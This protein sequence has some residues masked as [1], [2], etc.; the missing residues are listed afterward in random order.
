MTGVHARIAVL[1]EDGFDDD[2]LEFV[3]SRL[4]KSA[5]VPVL[6]GPVAHRAYR[7]RHG[8]VVL[9][10]SSSPA[11]A[12]SH[13]FA[14]IVIPAGYAP[15][16]LRMRHNVL[17]MVR[18]AVRDGTPVGAIGHGAQVL[19]SAGVIAGRTLTCWPSIAIDVKNAG[20]RYVD[21]PVVEDGGV[22]TARKADDAAAFVD[23][24]VQAIAR[25]SVASPNDTIA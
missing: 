22:I 12:R 2:A 11:A 19:I 20:G 3:L 18:D 10:S 25:V 16:R 5:A 24:V 6:V 21:R 23:A 13:K 8:R 9:T 14:G 7:G 17:D 4:T 15:D 1:L